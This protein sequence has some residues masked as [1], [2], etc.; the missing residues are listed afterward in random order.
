[1]IGD[2]ITTSFLYTLENPPKVLEEVAVVRD[3]L[4]VFREVHGLPSRRVVV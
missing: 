3:F 2:S 1:M 4:D